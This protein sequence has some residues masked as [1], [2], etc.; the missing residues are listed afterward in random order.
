ME[1][2]SVEAEEKKKE[3]K[4]VFTPIA[5]SDDRSPKD[6]ETDDDDDNDGNGDSGEELKFGK[7]YD[8]FEGDDD[9]QSSFFGRFKKK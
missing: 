8:I 1:D 3:K 4:N 5:E 7:D 2:I 6:D 9:S